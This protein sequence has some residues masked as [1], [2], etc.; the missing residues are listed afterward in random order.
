MTGAACWV[1]CMFSPSFIFFIGV[2]WM[3][4]SCL[5][6]QSLELVLF[7]SIIPRTERHR[8]QCP[9]YCSDVR[10]AYLEVKMWVLFVPPDNIISPIARIYLSEHVSTCIDTKLSTDRLEFGSNSRKL[11]CLQYPTYRPGIITLYKYYISSHFSFQV[12]C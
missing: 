5:N 12:I 11:L 1:C 9:T 10:W 4:S 7:F 8:R 3:G 6:Q 2:Q